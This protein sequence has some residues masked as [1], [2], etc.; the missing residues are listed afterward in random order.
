MYNP[1]TGVQRLWS[2]DAASR[3]WGLFCRGR[4]KRDAIPD[5]DVRLSLRRSREPI[6][7]VTHNGF[8]QLLPRRRFNVSRPGC[9][10]G[11][12]KPTHNARWP[13]RPSRLIRRGSAL[14]GISPE[15]ETGWY[16][17]DSG[18]FPIGLHAP[19]AFRRLE[20]RNPPGLINPTFFAANAPGNQP[21]FV[22][23]THQHATVWVRHSRHNSLAPPCVLWLLPVL[24]Q[25]GES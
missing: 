9:R 23:G 7:K 4:R 6:L 19:S 14:L 10:P 20:P 5:I 8:W 13:V 11:V 15:G 16:A 12:A 17:A 1:L 22:Q 25:P 24:T 2:W 3:L 21:V 18:C